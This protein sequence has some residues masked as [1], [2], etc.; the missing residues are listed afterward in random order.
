MVNVMT[1]SYDVI[2]VDRMELPGQ[3]SQNQSVDWPRRRFGR[4]HQLDE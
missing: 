1:A 3:G 4:N 2:R